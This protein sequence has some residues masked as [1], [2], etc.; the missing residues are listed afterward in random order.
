M[1]TTIVLAFSLLHVAFAG[2]Q[3]I[4]ECVKQVGNPPK[5]RPSV[6]SCQEDP[7]CPS[8]F[9]FDPNA[10]NEIA[11]NFDVYGFFIH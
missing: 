7:V 3:V 5:K 11:E 1:L 6:E 9:V 4:E 10:L 8:I 2:N